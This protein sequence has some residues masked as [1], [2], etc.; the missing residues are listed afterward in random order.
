MYIDSAS[1]RA[2]RGPKGASRLTHK[3]IKAGDQERP[4]GARTALTPARTGTFFRME[5]AKVDRRLVEE[6]KRG[7]ATRDVEVQ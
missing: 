6:K 3:H 7:N 4:G 1:R 2:S 5:F